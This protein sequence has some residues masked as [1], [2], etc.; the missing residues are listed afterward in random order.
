MRKSGV[1]PMRWCERRWPKAWAAAS[2]RVCIY[3]LAQEEV[4][5]RGIVGRRAGLDRAPLHSGVG[6]A[7]ARLCLR[8]LRLRASH[9]R[10]GRGGWHLEAAER[11]RASVWLRGD[12]F[13]AA[14]APAERPD[15][16][17]LH[18][19]VLIARPKRHAIDEASPASPHA[20]HSPLEPPLV[21]KVDLNGSADREGSIPNLRGSRLRAHARRLPRRPPASPSASPSASPCCRTLSSPT[22]PTALPLARRAAPSPGGPIRLPLRLPLRL[23]LE[24][25]LQLPLQPP[26]DLPLRLRSPF[27]AG[28]L[29]LSRL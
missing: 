22:S 21:V 25:P 17:A 14:A 29:R 26:L 10:R 5:R 23:L 11:V 6:D 4:R 16:G 24:L 13:R 9:V 12:A 1:E 20:N 19:V 18:V 7:K 15:L 28:R 3:G 8:L 27:P 2:V